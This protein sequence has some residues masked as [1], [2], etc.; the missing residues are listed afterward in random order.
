MNIKII[1]SGTIGAYAGYLLAKEGHEVALYEDH[2]KIGIPCH[3]TGILTSSFL[4]MVKLRE[5]ILLNRLGKVKVVAPNNSFAILPCSDIVV[6]RI[7]LDEYFTGLARDAGAKVLMGQK[8]A[9]IDPAKKEAIIEGKGGRKA[10]SYES[11]VSADG[12]N[13]K[14]FPLLNPKIKRQPWIGAQ[15]VIR[16]KFDREMYEVY[17]N[18]DYCKGFFAWVVPESEE[19]AIAGLAASERPSFHFERFMKKRFGDSFRKRISSYRGG[20]I[21]MHYPH[22]VCQKDGIFLV[23]DAGGHVKATTGGGIIP[24]M[25]A[26]KALVE[27]LKTGKSYDKLLRK[28]I[29]NNLWLHLK[30]RKMLDRFSDEDYNRLI[31]LMSREN[32]RRVIA[33]SDRE[34]P[35]AFAF[36]LLLAEP[37]LLGFVKHLF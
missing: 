4:G 26:A 30:I 9:S 12:P 27:S 20:L 17:L 15:A 1:G 2:E 37:R 36:K 33:D 24:G 19:S 29:G 14:V 25:K 3:C 31:A 21:P 34:Y 32:P 18:N 35:S 6:D 28:E 23:G 7:A 5:G 11:L 22:A 16:G 13:S 8:L 10:L